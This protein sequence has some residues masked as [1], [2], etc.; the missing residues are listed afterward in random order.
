MNMLD[1]STPW[2]HEEFE[3]KLRE[4]SKFYHFH[5]PFHQLMHAGK[6]NQKQVQGWVAKQVLLSDCHTC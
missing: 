2:S 4:K 6:M 5:H 3:A 1:D